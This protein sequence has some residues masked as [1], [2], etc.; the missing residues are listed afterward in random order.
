MAK[1]NDI[2]QIRENINKVDENLINRLIKLGKKEGL[3]S[4]YLTKVFYEIIE[5]SVRLQQNYIQNKINKG[6][7]RSAVSI[8]FQGI[9][10][11]YSYLAAQK[12]FAHSGYALNFVFRKLFS[13]VV[14]AAEKGEADYAILP[15]ENTTSGGINEVYDL[16]LHTSL[17]IIGEEKYHVNH[18]LVGIKN[19]P[20]EKIKKIYAHHQAASQCSKFLET[21]PEISVEYFV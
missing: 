12:Y 5:D 20:F 16:M 8:S 13:E 9:E 7:K 3:D 15:I 18:C 17:S 14:E 6:E 4:H 1:K 19:A 21:L 10:G 11:S 2:S